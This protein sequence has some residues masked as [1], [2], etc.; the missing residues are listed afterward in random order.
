MASAFPG[1]SDI[2]LY[3]YKDSAA[4]KAVTGVSERTYFG[5]IY[6]NP[7]AVIEASVGDSVTAQAQYISDKTNRLTKSVAA[8]WQVNNDGVWEDIDTNVS[9]TTSSHIGTAVLDYS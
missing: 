9:D 1:C 4:D 5:E 2:N 7:P 6:T 3:C 8:T